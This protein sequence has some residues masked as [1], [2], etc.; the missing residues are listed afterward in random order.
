[1]TAETEDTNT[2]TDNVIQ[3]RPHAD[4]EKILHQKWKSSLDGG[5]AA[6]PSVLIHS[7]QGLRIRAPELAVLVCLIDLWWLPADMPWPSKAKIAERLG[8]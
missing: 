2:D 6:V 5:F 4:T 8:V 7:L 3:L 1:M